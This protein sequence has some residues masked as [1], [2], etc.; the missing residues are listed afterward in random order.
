MA[1]ILEAKRPTIAQ[2]K[3]EIII[4]R[5]RNSELNTTLHSAKI[6]S[7]QLRMSNQSYECRIRNL[8]EDINRLR[9]KLGMKDA[10]RLYTTVGIVGFAFILGFVLGILIK[11]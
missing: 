10:K 8:E 4:L 3:A 2:C 7:E 6:T 9:N 11:L 5:N 1:D